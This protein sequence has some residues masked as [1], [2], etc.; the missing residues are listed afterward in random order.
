[1]KEIG[2]PMAARLM[3]KGLKPRII[4]SESNGR[5]T[6]REETSLKTKSI[7]FTP[8]VEFDETT[9]Y[10]HDIKV[11]LDLYYDIFFL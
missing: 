4:I 6:L 8:D 11:D 1:M 10:G 2:V 7:T 5:W 9:A 3:A